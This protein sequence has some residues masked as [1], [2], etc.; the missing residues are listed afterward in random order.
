MK[1][2]F[3]TSGNDL[4]GTLDTRFGRAHRFLVYNLDNDTFEMVDNRQNVNAAQGAGAQSA[5][6]VARLG[7]KAIVTGHCGPRAFRVLQT[8][9]IRVFNTT[10]LTVAE[11]LEQY[12][13]GKLTEA[14][15]AD[16]G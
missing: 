4:N 5:E 2:V 11:A 8:A 13:A 3:T 12:R 6:V 15:S 7:A 1:I 14:K 16:A 10:A 9:G